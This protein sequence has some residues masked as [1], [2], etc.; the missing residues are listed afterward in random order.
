MASSNQ[1]QDISNVQALINQIRDE[2]VE[3]ASQEAERLVR[4]AK[5]EAAAIR[6]QAK[7]EIDKDRSKAE[8][9]MAAEKSAALEA[10]QLAARD[11]IL[12][13][14]REVIGKFEGHVKRLVSENLKDENILHDLILA[15][16]G[17]CA[18]QMPIGKNFEILIS[19]NSSDDDAMRKFILKVTC[20][21]LQEGIEL[22]PVSDRFDGIRVHIKDDDLEI[23]LTE[24]AV[25]G[26]LMQHLL[27]RYRK[28]VKGL[29]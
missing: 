20:D 28:I 4:E 6:Q 13:L 23:D 19:E 2:G 21:M 9:E 22:K 3:A 18:G 17:K 11:S 27:P 15:V 26:L 16:A 8:K 12:R 14:G 24:N 10:L 29:E 1:T 5:K 25:T 7:T